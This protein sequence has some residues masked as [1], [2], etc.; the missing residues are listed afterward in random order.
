M[1][2]ISLSRKEEFVELLLFRARRFA[3]VLSQL[4][5][6]QGFDGFAGSPRVLKYFLLLVA[7]SLQLLQLALHQFALLQQ[8]RFRGCGES[9]FRR[10]SSGYQFTRLLNPQL[11][12]ARIDLLDQVRRARDSLV[13]SAQAQF[14]LMLHALPVMKDDLERKTK[15]HGIKWAV[16]AVFPRSR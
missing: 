12:Q 11:L 14:L 10:G 5:F 3:L 4:F 15:G 9:P 6:A 13:R 7:Q 2:Q 8:S 1:P 16:P